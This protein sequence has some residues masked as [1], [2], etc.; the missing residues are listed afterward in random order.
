MILILVYN[1]VNILCFCLLALGGLGA[2]Y[3]C[4]GNDV[5]AAEFLQEALLIYDKCLPP[6]HSC[7]HSALLLLGSIA[8][9]QERYD[10]SLHFYERAYDSLAMVSPESEQ[11]AVVKD[12]IARIYR[13]LSE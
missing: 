9:S 1:T 10:E 3:A 12:Q 5:K 6:T 11:T 8:V 7:V 2:A 13:M 4:K